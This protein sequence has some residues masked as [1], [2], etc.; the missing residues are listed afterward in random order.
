MTER[1]PFCESKVESTDS[2]CPACQ[3]SLDIE[4]PYCKQQIK[5]YDKT[6]PYCTTKLV[7][8]DY[9]KPMVILA[10][11]LS[12]TW[13]ISNIAI[14]AIF[15]YWPQVFVTTGKR[16]DFYVADYEQFCACGLAIPF[17][18]FIILAVCN[19]KLKNYAI[20][21]IVINSIIFVIFSIY[22]LYLKFNFT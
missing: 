6:C 16:Q 13:C 4:C 12:I 2:V 14:L 18:I 5:A 8:S 20:L 7:K 21:G 17:I 22:A 15:S 19:R 3:S 11:V 10:T 1:C 9:S